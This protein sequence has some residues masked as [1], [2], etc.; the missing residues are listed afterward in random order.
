MLI[1][2]GN[3]SRV[4]SIPGPAGTEGLPTPKGGPIL[5]GTNVV[6]SDDHK[7]GHVVGEQGDYLIVESGA[8]RKHKHVLPK[9]FSGELDGETIR[10][11]VT[12]DIL[13]D[14][15]E[16]DGDG[17]FDE[18]AVARHYGLASSMEDAPAEGYGE[19]V[20]DDPAYADAGVRAA[21]QE[22]VSIREQ[23]SDPGLGSPDPSPGVTGGDRFRDTPGAKTSDE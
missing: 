16:A 22:R 18:Q 15:P 23:L 21:E 17:A 13:R 19:T 2:Y 7:A 8:L 14:A 5:H 9:A 12:W 10:A 6:T 3:G 20:A 1:G 4:V 11:T